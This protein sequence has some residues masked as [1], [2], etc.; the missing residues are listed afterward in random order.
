MPS[1]K[2]DDWL[3]RAIWSERISMLLIGLYCLIVFL[4][5]L[6]FGLFI[7]FAAGGKIWHIE[8]GSGAF[9]LFSIAYVV[10]TFALNRLYH[11]LNR[12]G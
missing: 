9:E 7:W 2:P 3:R 8:N 11:R 12:H 5:W 1:R 6:C 10:A 4:G